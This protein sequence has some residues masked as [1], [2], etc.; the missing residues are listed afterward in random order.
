MYSWCGLSS[1]GWRRNGVEITAIRRSSSRLFFFD[2]R[3][4]AH[5]GER[6]SDISVLL[7]Q[8]IPFRRNSPNGQSASAISEGST[9][10]SHH[11][12][13]G[14]NQPPRGRDEG[15][16]PEE[17]ASYGQRTEKQTRASSQKPKPP[18]DHCDGGAGARD[19]CT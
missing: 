10:N 5:R 6:L 3:A 9:G 17:G 19:G 2:G 4:I 14:H 8:G 18:A 16:Q 11:P 15:A 13:C 12:G 7:L 1:D